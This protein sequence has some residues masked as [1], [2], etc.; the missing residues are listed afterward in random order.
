[1]NGAPRYRE[2]SSMKE[3][4]ANT[5]SFIPHGRRF[6]SEA[7]FGVYKDHMGSVLH[8]ELGSWMILRKYVWSDGQ[9]WELC[10]KH[11]R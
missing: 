8:A 2:M 7:G 6:P 1:M 11:H 3:G 4:A 5:F 10:N 9:G